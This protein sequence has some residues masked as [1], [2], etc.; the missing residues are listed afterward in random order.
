M[1]KVN[2]LPPELRAEMN[3][4]ANKLKALRL[5]GAVALI[6]GLNFVLLFSLTLQ[7]KR[8]VFAKEQERL[9]V[10]VKETVFAPYLQAKNRVQRQ[11]GL[12]KIAMGSPLPWRDTLSALGSHIPQ[13]VWLTNLTFSKNGELVLQGLTFDHPAV[14]NWLAELAEIPGV[15]N[16]RLVFSAEEAV[17]QGFLVRFEVRAALAA[18]QEYAPLQERGE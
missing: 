17:E 7:L 12:A 2:L 1:I 4:R 18:G 3:S 13:N 5:V 15:S 14:A 8:Q 9:A 10:E 16:V 6:L 11:V